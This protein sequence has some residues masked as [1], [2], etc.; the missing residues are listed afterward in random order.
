MLRYCTG[1]SEGL[2]SL[3]CYC[4]R[5]RHPEV[6]NGL[7]GLP[8]RTPPRQKTLGWKSGTPL[9]CF[10]SAPRSRQKKL[11]LPSRVATGTGT[12][13][14]AGM[15]T[16]PPPRVVAH[17]RDGNGN[18][19]GVAA[20]RAPA[21]TRWQQ[22][23]S[24][25]HLSLSCFHSIG[26]G[27][28]SAESPPPSPSPAFL[29]SQGDTA[30]PFG[31]PVTF[32]PWQQG[33]GAPMGEASRRAQPPAASAAALSSTALRRTESTHSRGRRAARETSLWD[34]LNAHGER[35]PLF[36]SPFHQSQP[37]RKGGR[38][39]AGISG[40]AHQSRSFIRPETCQRCTSRPR[41]FS[42]GG[43]HFSVRGAK[44]DLFGIQ[45]IIFYG[46]WL[47]C[48]FD[49]IILLQ[50]LGAKAGD[51]F[52]SASLRKYHNKL[53]CQCGSCTCAKTCVL[54]WLWKMSKKGDAD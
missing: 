52:Q 18:G 29:S 31:T 49:S 44:R 40:L 27:V 4:P 33:R 5:L 11:P 8:S 6:I 51:I 47:Y 24:W 35:V 3:Q 22:E 50:E 1:V 15:C 19:P 39:S 23:K 17:G 42:N 32:L 28:S 45:N 7:W 26:V 41:L 14:W 30:N 16:C 12:E 10:T 21:P 34:N 54:K 48:C 37:G 20:E 38:L 25:L 36:G 53:S 9:G 46:F 13:E 2:H 43:C